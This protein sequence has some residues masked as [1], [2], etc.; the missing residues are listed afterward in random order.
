MEQLKITYQ[1]H[2]WALQNTNKIFNVDKINCKKRNLIIGFACIL[3]KEYVLTL[4]KNKDDID[5]IY[6]M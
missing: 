5:T 2:L 1:K 4:K 6:K 3:N